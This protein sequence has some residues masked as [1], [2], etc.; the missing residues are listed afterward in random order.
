ML[1]QQLLA[2]L[3]FLWDDPAHQRSARARVLW[4]AASLVLRYLFVVAAVACTAAVCVAVRENAPP[5]TLGASYSFVD[6][7][8]PFARGLRPADATQR[9]TLALNTHAHSTV[10]PDGEMSPAQVVAWHASYGYDA[11]VM[12]DH[13]AF[14]GFDEARR[15]ARDD[16]ND[17]IIVLPG[18]EW[19]TGRGHYNFIGVRS[20][21][22]VHAGDSFLRCPSDEEMQAAIDECHAAGCVV[23]VNHL[24][25]SWSYGHNVPGLVDL[26]AWGVD[27]VEVAANWGV[28]MQSYTWALQHGMGVAAGIDV[29]SPDSNAYAYTTLA[30]AARSEEAIM[31]ELRARRTSFIYST[32][33]VRSMVATPGRRNSRYW[34]QRPLILFGSFVNSLYDHGTQVAAAPQMPHARFCVTRSTAAARAVAAASA[35]GAG[36]AMDGGT[37]AALFFWSLVGFA[38]WEAVRCGVAAAWEG[39][40]AWAVARMREQHGFVKMDDGHESLQTLCQ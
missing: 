38:A 36:E 9:P 16:W 15:A 29:H 21:H 10:S 22:R 3:A 24:P 2:R 8:G 27:Y 33:S 30:P 1:K 18:V 28:D 7:P 20:L 6:R 25:Y 12:T 39:G 37:L 17:T 23:T 11:F 26:L 4:A 34:F 31:A 32:L 13:N 35:G 40:R 5:E 14:S 19:S